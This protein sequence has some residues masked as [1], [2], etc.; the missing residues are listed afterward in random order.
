MVLPADGRGEREGPWRAS[1]AVHVRDLD[2]SRRE[3]EGVRVPVDGAGRVGR[4]VARRGAVSSDPGP[5]GTAP[6]HIVRRVG[7]MVNRRRVALERGVRRAD[8]RVANSARTSG[9]TTRRSAPS[10]RGRTSNW[11]PGGSSSRPASWAWSGGMT[12]RRRAISSPR[13][14]LKMPRSV[15]TVVS[16]THPRL[17]AGNVLMA[18][19]G[20]PE[21][22]IS[23]D[24]DRRSPGQDPRVVV[25]GKAKHQQ[26]AQIDRGH[27]QRP[28]GRCGDAAV[29]HPAGSRRRPARRSSVPPSAASAGSSAGSCGSSAAAGGAQLLLMR[30]DARNTRLAVVQRP[31]SGQPWQCRAKLAWPDAVIDAVAPAG[32]LTVPAC[33]SMRKS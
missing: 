20:R 1:A 29:G 9:R 32:H 16:A 31:R 24:G 15:R 6:V 19:S 8:A 4:A 27:P 18:G 17:P 23:P 10:S 14:L 2:C 33:W 21:T 26:S 12:T 28:P 13:S 30:V 5:S 11:R 25:A 7:P 22:M 3:R